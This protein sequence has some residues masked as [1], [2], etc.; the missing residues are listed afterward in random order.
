ML[1]GTLRAKLA[2][3]AAAGF[4]LTGLM[5]VLVLQ[6]TRDAH[7][8]VQQAEASH[9]RMRVF[10]RLQSTANRLQQL[11][12]QK[13]R[14]DDARSAAEQRAAR[15]DFVAALAALRASPQSSDTDRR[16]VVTV[17][18]EG[19]AVL[20]LFSHGKDIV[21]AVD[22]AWRTGGSHA[23][24][25]EVQVRSEPYRV[26]ADTVSREV[27]REDQRVSAATSRAVAG[28]HAVRRAAL[29]GLALA[30]ALSVAVFAVLLTR[31]GPGL[32]RLARGARAFG[33]GDLAH[34]IHLPGRDELA[35]L[36]AVFNSMARE[37]S[38]KQQALQEHRAGLERAVAERTGELER[39]NA[40]LSAE[41]ERRRTFLAEASHEL[42]MPLTIIR[43]EAQVALRAGDQG[44]P[45][46][47]EALERILEQTRALTRLL[48][49]LFLIARAEAGGLRL[50][51]RTA[52]LGELVLRVA[53]DF[54]TI[55]CES[56]ATV[57]ADAHGGI[58]ARIDPD[59]VR[60][61]LAALIDNALRHTRPGVNV[62]VG[63]RAEDGWITIAVSDDGPGIDPAA[64]AELFGRF[65]RGRTRSDGSGLGLTVVR[66]LAE[67][68][69]GTASIGNAEQGG[70]RAV[71]RLPWAAEPIMAKTA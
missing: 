49:D 28:Q 23:A 69:G 25:V 6:T 35:E 2:A 27:E 10:A 50:N 71:L 52:D 62:H 14:T 65:R 15:D 58:L 44:G 57:R 13:V 48:D 18:R 24:L 45:D 19:E 5:T 39:A 33:S 66:A 17:E 12:Y 61:A 26:F 67:A 29:V 36:A 54:S 34:R 55:A 8:V 63:A 59:R 60:Q 11:T 30:L 37:L 22:Q 7:Q 56:G 42:R 32:K 68:H 47:T 21:K 4:V 31:L 43:G 16:L 1:L 46:A 51:L 3:T 53:L 38:D 40:A 41:D 9:D 20:G 64:A 70:A